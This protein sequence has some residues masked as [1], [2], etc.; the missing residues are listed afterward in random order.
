MR[1]RRRLSVGQAHMAAEQDKALL[2]EQAKEKA[3]LAV[4]KRRHL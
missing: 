1:E 3:K 2:V 4:V